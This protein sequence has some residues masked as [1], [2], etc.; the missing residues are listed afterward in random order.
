MGAGSPPRCHCRTPT[1]PPE[2]IL[3]RARTT[4]IRTD[5]LR[6]SPRSRTARSRLSTRWHLSTRW[7]H[8]PRRRNPRRTGQIAGNR[9][10]DTRRGHTPWRRTPGRRIPDQRRKPG[11]R[12]RSAMRSCPGPGSPGRSG[13]R[14]PGNR[15]WC[16]AGIRSRPTSCRGGLRPTRRRVASRLSYPPRPSV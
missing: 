8:T 7:R 1:R 15:P 9:C 2:E 4:P 12:T 13:T 11:R 14:F 5:R 10:P 16:P 6:R 3:T